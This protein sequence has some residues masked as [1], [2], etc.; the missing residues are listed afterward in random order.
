MIIK[1]YKYHGAGND[2][3]ILDDREFNY[4]FSIKKIKEICDRK[5][6]IGSDGFIL[7]RN[8][9]K[10][11][12][13]MIYFNSDGK[14]SS[15]CGNGGRCIVHFAYF[16][17]IIKSS[18]VFLAIDGPHE[19][20]IISDSKVILKMNNIDEIL[21]FKN[22]TFIDSGSPHHIIEKS[23]IDLIDVKQIG[24][25]IRYSKIYSPN[26]VN[27]NFIKKTSSKEFMVRTYERGVE[28][29]TLSCGSGAVASAIAMHS[30]GRTSQN[31]IK[32]K[33]LGGDLVVSFKF[34][35]TY[36]GVTLEG[37]VKQVFKGEIVF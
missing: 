16:L 30:K 2:F 25:K 23:K 33:T 8:H 9:K 37:P 19:A 6:G 4:S 3:I 22:Y 24:S 35:K 34:N 5:N 15:M 26:G 7:L 32:I 14:I 12:F 17:K 1:F 36:S 29:E 20:Q 10:Y 18:T 13:E 27:V 31:K 11:D 28:D 21:K